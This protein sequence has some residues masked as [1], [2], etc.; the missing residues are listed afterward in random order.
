MK[1]LE[2]TNEFKRKLKA[3]GL[4]FK[5]TQTYGSCIC[6][7]LETLKSKY[8]SPLFVTTRDIEDYIIHLRELKRS[9]S[10]INQFIISAKRF[11][12]L[13][14][15]PNKCKHLKYMDRKIKTPNVL[16]YDECL[17]M[18]NTKSYIKHRAIINILYYCALRRNEVRNLKIS[19]LSKDGKMVIV[20]SKFGKSRTIPVPEHVMILLREY[21][22]QVKPKK[23]LFN[24]EGT[25]EQYSERSIEN[26]VKNVA[27]L[28]KIHKRVHPHLLRSSR[29]THLLDNGASDMYVSEFLGH[30][31]IQTTKDY[32]CKLT[33]N[34]MQDNFNKVDERLKQKFAA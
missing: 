5:T 8:E 6:L 31:K 15:Q 9:N 27:V 25:I 28:C 30:E 11:F 14:G 1:I 3:D 33:I 29:A 24:G 19:D 10:Y 7:F 21:Y 16:T 34:G 13:N 20:N 22:R 17:K 12:G 23:Y 2:F 32:Y 18:C 4:D 26:V